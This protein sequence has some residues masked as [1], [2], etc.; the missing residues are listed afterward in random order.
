MRDGTQSPVGEI[1]EYTDIMYNGSDLLYF[2]Y[3][4]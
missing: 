2:I 4:N 3:D 1:P